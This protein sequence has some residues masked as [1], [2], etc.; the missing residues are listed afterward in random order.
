MAQKT[1]NGKDTY[2]V[3]LA[4]GKGTRLWPLSRN[5]FP[6]QLLMLFEGRSLLQLT[7]NH[8]KSV[9]PA[10]N[11]LVVTSD[12]Y[13]RHVKKQLPEL[14]EYNLLCE[15]DGRSTLP[16]ILWAALKIGAG[17]VLM[18]LNSD[19][20]IQDVNQWKRAIRTA[21][22]VARAHKVLITLGIKPDRPHTGFGY[23]EL[24]R[25]QGKMFN[26]P[27]YKAQKFHEKPGLKKAKAYLES[28][29]FLW[30]SGMFIWKT[31]TFIEACKEFVSDI[32]EPMKQAGSSSAK[33]RKAYASIR[34]EG[35]DYGVLEHANNVFVIPSIFG[36]SDLGDWLVFYERGK[37][38]ENNN[39]LE[40]RVYSDNAKDS[41]MLSEDN[42]LLAVNDVKDMIIVVNKDVVFISSKKGLSNM[43]PLLSAIKEK[44][45]EKHL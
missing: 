35:V 19:N 31:D 21:F 14:K 5:A 25:K 37:K 23:I 4:G 22:S 30:N 26:V 44:G 7:F 36:W 41:L 18:S 16:P 15:P 2:C 29:R 20:W 43:K 28:G 9:V 24:G 13:K 40:G 17:K 11:I 3:I 1:Q 27:Y 8:A 38:D 42:R 34:G 10:E 39:V 12:A 32:Y 6:K 33:M 45:Y